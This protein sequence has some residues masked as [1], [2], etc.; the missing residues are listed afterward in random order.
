MEWIDLLEEDK[1]E[2]KKI[3][4]SL[5]G[6]TIVSVSTGEPLY[7]DK[8]NN[9]YKSKYLMNYFIKYLR[10]KKLIK[11]KERINETSMEM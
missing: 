7:F 1:Q 11:L 3:F 8:D 6:E 2:Y 9:T 5:L 10:N 4:D